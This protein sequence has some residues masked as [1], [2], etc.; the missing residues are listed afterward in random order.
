VG[1]GFANEVLIWGKK[2]TA[3]ELLQCGFYKYAFFSTLQSSHPT[4]AYHFRSKIFPEQSVESFHDSVRSLLLAEL[5][6]LDPTALLVVRSL[7][8][9]GL[10]EKNDPDAV[11]LREAYGS[12]F[13]CYIAVNFWSDSHLHCSAQAE[14]FASGVPF[15]QFV[16]IANKEIKHKL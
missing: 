5:A 7:I 9:R 14:R 12:S 16:R 6:G 4:L 11:N 2:K 10:H 3:D 13:C 8:R 1:V 15:T